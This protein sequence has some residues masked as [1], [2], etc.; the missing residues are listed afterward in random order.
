M[1]RPK[2]PT[3]RTAAQIIHR[4]RTDLEVRKGYIGLL[5]RLV[6]LLLLG[7]FALTQLVY[8]MQA[9]D[10][11]MFPAVKAGDLVIA[12]R[13]ETDYA[14]EDVVVY[15]VDGTVKIGRII[16]RETDIVTMDESGQLLVN[17]TTQTGEIVFSTYPSE[18]SG[19]V[20]PYTV[21]EGCVFILCDYRTQG[22]DSREYGPI[23]LEDIRG[24]V[25][26]ILRRRDI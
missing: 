25:I 23:A 9:Q 14:K 17:G 7:W 6:I 18:D 16:A 19:I 12:W 22:T 21:P 2:Q 13:L 26:T 4:R 15:E 8:V 20:Y 1:S 11:E 3:N 5:L 24:K 10:N